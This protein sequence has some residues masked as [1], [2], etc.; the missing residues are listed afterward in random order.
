MFENYK[1]QFDIY[2]LRTMALD[3][4]ITNKDNDKNDNQVVENNKPNNNE[5]LDI[6]KYL[7]LMKTYQK[8]F[9]KK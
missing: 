9:K 8:V 5:I 4:K 6:S 3:E 7:L 1:F 2:E